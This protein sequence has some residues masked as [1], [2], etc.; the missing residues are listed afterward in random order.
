MVRPI[1]V[2]HAILQTSAIE[3]IQQA[4]QQ[5]PGVQQEYLELQLKEERTSPE[6][7]SKRLQRQINQRS[8]IGKTIKKRSFPSA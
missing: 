4:Q 3:K 7:R 1:D 5:H 2:Q 6:K 8:R